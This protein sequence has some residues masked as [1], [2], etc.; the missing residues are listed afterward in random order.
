MTFLVIIELVLNRI[1]DWEVWMVPVVIA[2]CGTCWWLHFNNRVSR[3]IQLYICG[4]F[5]IFLVFYYCIRIKA[6]YDC[7]SVILIMIFVFGFTREKILIW[8]GGRRS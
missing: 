3:R 6:V 2:G 1:L 5:V 7:G 4:A 8:A